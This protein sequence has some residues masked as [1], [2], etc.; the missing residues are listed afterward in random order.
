V[1]EPYHRIDLTG[2][3]TLIRQALRGGAVEA[4]TADRLAVNS[5]HHLAVRDLAPGLRV[6]ARSLDGIIEAF[7]GKADGPFL[8]CVQFHPEG[9]TAG[10]G[11]FLRLFELFVEAAGRYRASKVP[12]GL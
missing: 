11:P 3:G 10:G 9:L 1:D 4:P 8:L 12:A 2:D 7:E 5:F 6:T